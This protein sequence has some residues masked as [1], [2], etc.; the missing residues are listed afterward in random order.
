MNGQPSTTLVSGGTVAVPSAGLSS[1]N[2][3]AP[4]PV[5][6]GTYTMTASAPS[7]QTFVACGQSGVTLN[8]GSASQSVTVPAGGA[9]DGKF[10][11]THHHP[12]HSG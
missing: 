2:P 1:A 7:G 12:D 10:Y 8:G 3:L 5:A 4:S 6:A 9:G 11:V